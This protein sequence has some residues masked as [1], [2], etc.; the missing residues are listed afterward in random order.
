[1][2][3]R[4]RLLEFQT[5]REDA[6]QQWQAQMA[7]DERRWREEQENKAE[8]RHRAEL[9]Q[10]NRIHKTEMWVTGG[11]VTLAIIIITTLGAA[12][13][14]GWVPKWFGLFGN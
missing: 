7:E 10:L 4:Q 14:A 3:D 11:A 6:W 13:E 2:L 8:Q 5:S 1:M 9:A 12:I